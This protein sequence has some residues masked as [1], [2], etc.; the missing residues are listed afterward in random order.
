MSKHFRF[1]MGA[2]ALAVAVTGG[3]TACGDDDGAAA[4]GGGRDDVAQAGTGSGDAGSGDAG[5]GD[6]AEEGRAFGSTDDAVITAL[7]TATKADEV[8]WDGSTV[9]LTFG[10]GSA[11]SPTAY[12]MCGPAESLIAEDESARLVYPD[13]HV[14][15][16]DRPGS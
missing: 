3:V 2:L 11:E 5:S 9:V 4:S 6:E 7:T 1:R 12:L 15:C 16:N 13:G 10:D 8:T 14:D